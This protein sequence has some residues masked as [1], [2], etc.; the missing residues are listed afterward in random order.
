MASSDPRAPAM[1]EKT[2]P[3]HFIVVEIFAVFGRII[4]RELARGPTNKSSIFNQPSH[5]ELHRNENVCM[6]NYGIASI[7]K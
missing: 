7:L 5:F 3:P 1:V 2:N 6:A 4:F